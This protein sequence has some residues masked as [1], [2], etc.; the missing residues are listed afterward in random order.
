MNYTVD[1][2]K[3][4]RTLHFPSLA[5]RG[6][7]HGFTSRQG[8]GES[9]EEAFAF[10]NMGLKT[11]ED[12]SLVKRNHR[13]FLAGVGLEDYPLVTGQQVHGSHVSLAGSCEGFCMVPSSDGLVTAVEGQV[14]GL[15]SADCAIL[16][17][18]DVK[19][20]AVGIAHAGWRGA[21]AGIGSK[22]VALMEKSFGILPTDLQV[23]IS[24]C[25]EPCCFEI[26]EDVVEALRDRQIPPKGILVPAVSPGTWLMNL[27]ALNQYQLREAGVPAAQIVSTGLCTFCRRDL[28]YSY[29]RDQGITGRMMGYVYLTKK[30]RLRNGTG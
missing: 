25:I 6:T 30:G 8:P 1:N 13:H 17:F 19:G 23:A 24:P 28:F 15:F 14:L 16:F 9:R 10:L 4:F 20:R 18:I 22:T 5:V 29:R 21:L 27:T 2:H 11:G 12:P 3:G 7:G 26:K